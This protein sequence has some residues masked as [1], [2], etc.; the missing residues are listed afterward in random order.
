MNKRLHYCLSIFFSSVLLMI[1]C[2]QEEREVID[3]TLD[4]TISKDSQLAQ[5]MKNVVTH[6]GSYDNLVD[7]SNCF[8]INLPYTIILNSTDQI[9]IDHVS[10][11]SQLSQSD[12]IEIQFPIIITRDNYEEEFVEDISEL[13]SLADGCEL[14]DDDIECVDFVYP[15]RFQTF[16]PDTN[17]MN[18][19]EV[20]HDAQV[21]EFMN[22]IDQNTAVSISYPIQLILSNGEH[23]DAGHNEE[24]VA[25]ILSFEMSCD[26]NDE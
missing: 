24:L 21:F 3:P 13:Q 12:T 11:Y 1:S 25:G 22:N 2:Q 17:N 19:T 14:T 10:D 5:L 4:T 16:D 6:D 15:F 18:T 8:S 26:E 20:A 7:G 23:L 9:T